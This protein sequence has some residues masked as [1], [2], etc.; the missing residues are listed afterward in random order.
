MRPAYLYRSEAF[1]EDL[2]PGDALQRWPASG[3]DADRS[4]VRAWAALLMQTWR[5]R[6]RTPEA[7]PRGEVGALA[8]LG[9][10]LRGKAG[11]AVTTAAAAE[12]TIALAGADR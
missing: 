2:E 9:L 4:A 1:A 5:R 8:S 12:T 7:R 10:G 3:E 6:A 11:V